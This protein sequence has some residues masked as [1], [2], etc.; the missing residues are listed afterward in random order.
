MRNDVF[1]DVLHSMLNK[2]KGSLQFNIKIGN[3][4]TT[5]VPSVFQKLLERKSLKIPY[6]K[7]LAVIHDVMQRL[8]MHVVLRDISVADNCY[9]GFFSLK[10]LLYRVLYTDHIVVLVLASRESV[11]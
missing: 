7:S 11:F 6:S 9:L 5:S 4:L 1:S 10:S 8:L 3:K 2:K